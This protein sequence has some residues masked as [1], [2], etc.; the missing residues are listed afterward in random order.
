[1]LFAPWGRGREQHTYDST[2]HG[3]YCLSRRDSRG[4]VQPQESRVLELFDL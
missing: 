2:L 3:E 1:M 4:L